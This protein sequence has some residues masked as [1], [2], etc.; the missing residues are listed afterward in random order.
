M[1]AKAIKFEISAVDKATTTI[2]KINDSISKMTRPYANLSKS[3]KGFADVSG[4]NKLGSALGEVVNKTKSLFSSFTKLAVPFLSLVGAGSIASLAQMISH[5][6][7][8]GA[9]LERTSS[10]L[11]ISAQK[12]NSMRGAAQLTGVSGEDLTSGFKSLSDTLQDAKWGRNNAAYLGLQAMGI[13]LRQTKDGAID[14]EQAMYDLAD[15]LHQIQKTDPAAART[16]SRMFGVE[17]ILPLLVKGSTALRS[18]QAEASKLKGVFTPEMAA[19]ATDFFRATEGMNLS[20]EG[21][22]NTISDK[23]YPIIQP[24]ITQFTNWAVANRELIS[25]RI[26]EYVS[27]LADWLKSVDWLSFLDGVKDSIVAVA[28]FASKLIGWINKIGGIKAVLIALGIYMAG[29]FALSLVAAV[30]QVGLLAAAFAGLDIAIAPVAIALGAVA[31]VGYGAYKIASHFLNNDSDKT[32][33]GASTDKQANIAGGVSRR[34]LKWRSKLNL[35]EKESRYGL[36]KGMLTALMEQESA[37]NASA[38][39]SAGARGLFQFIPETAKEYG[40]DATDPSQSSE[41]AA[42][43]LSGLAKR[44]GGDYTKAL[45]AYNWGEGNLDRKGLNNAPDETK[46]YASQIYGRMDTLNNSTSSSPAI[47]VQNTVNIDKNGNVTIATKTPSSSKIE[48][49]AASP[50]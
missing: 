20:L 47:N 36:P 45:S 29:G 11:G 41:A 9:E 10:L 44:Y 7:R 22:K 5:F 32:E 31:A 15:K 49:I 18:Y 8:M 25:T 46:K 35:D 34:S 21:L 30:T 6:S 48:K 3:M 28:E 4:L 1:S 19:R 24:L 40:I 33:S 13:T 16:L 50:Y 26:A 37:G 43:K 27:E 14:T 42:K 12:L 17:N 23:L 2:N 39:S 38:V